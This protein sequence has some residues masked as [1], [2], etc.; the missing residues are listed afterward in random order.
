M[1]RDRSQESKP[2]VAMIDESTATTPAQ[3]AAAVI[4]KAPASAAEKIQDRAVLDHPQVEVPVGTG[5]QPS[6]NE[7]HSPAN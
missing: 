4:N 1:R 6:E 3:T 2:D 7:S 5:D